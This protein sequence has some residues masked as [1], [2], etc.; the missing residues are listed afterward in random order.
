[1]IK[2]F[3][4]GT[5]FTLT[6]QNNGAAAITP[7]AKAL[8]VVFKVPPVFGPMHWP[9]ARLSNGPWNFVERTQYQTKVNRTKVLLFKS[10]ASHPWLE[11]PDARPVFGYRLVGWLI[12]H[13]A[14]RQSFTFGLRMSAGLGTRERG[15]GSPGN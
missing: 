2:E 9:V 4:S 13:E 5:G 3:G 11:Q 7:N 10:I 15:S 8:S 6:P 12:T 14:I 1:M